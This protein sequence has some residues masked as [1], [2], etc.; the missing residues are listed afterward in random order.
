M[1]PYL[2]WELQYQT[3][4]IGIQT[5]KIP[6]LKI[7][8][9]PYSTFI[10]SYKSNLQLMILCILAQFV[11]RTFMFCITQKLDNV[12]CQCTMCI[13]MCK[14]GVNT[15]IEL[16][17]FCKTI[18]F[19]AYLMTKDWYISLPAVLQHSGPA[20]PLIVQRL[21]AIYSSLAQ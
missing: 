15:R 6:R 5:L 11:P 3:N 20:G 17:N 8:T 12:G 14:F 10:L 21:T 13:S 7:Q 1:K 4:V 2:L 19:W 18:Q 9:L 16:W